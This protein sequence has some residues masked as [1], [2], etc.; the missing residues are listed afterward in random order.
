MGMVTWR[1]GL[2]FTANYSRVVTAKNLVQQTPP[3]ISW[4]SLLSA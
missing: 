3:F 4:N 1:I 2:G